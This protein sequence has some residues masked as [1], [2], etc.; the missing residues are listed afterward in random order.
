MDEQST[1]RMDPSPFAPTPASNQALEFHGFPKQ[2]DQQ[3]LDGDDEG[4]FI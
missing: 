1:M 2:D 3:Q 4:K